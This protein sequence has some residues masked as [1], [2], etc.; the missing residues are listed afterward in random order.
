MAIIGIDLGTTNSLAC[1]WHEGKC[2][3]IPNAFGEVFTPS[4][5]SVNDDGSMSVGKA[6]KER[7][8]SHPDST[9]A[10]FKRFMGTGKQFF[11]Q[12]K[13]FSAPELS[14]FV[15]R[16]LKDDAEVWLNEE[17]SEAIISVPAY[18]N[19]S[20]RAATKLAG[21]LAGVNVERLVNEPSAAALAYRSQ[22]QK[23]DGCFIVFDFGG[24]TLDVSVVECFENI[25]EIISVAGS[26]RLGGDDF[27]HIIANEFCNENK[28]N[29]D[30][31]SPTERSI[32]L[33]GA[34]QCKLNLSSAPIGK[35][36]VDLPGLRGALDITNETLARQSS[37]ILVG[38]RNVMERALKDCGKNVDEIDQVILVGGSCNMPLVQQ[39]VK[40]LMRDYSE[41]IT[42]FVNMPSP[43]AVVAVGVGVYAGIKERGSEIRDMLLTD[44]CP[45]TLGI[46]THN[47]SDHSRLFMSPIIERN[48][49]LPSSR[50]N[51]YYTVYDNQTEIECMIYQG[52]EMHADN[53][54]L[55]GNLKIKVPPAP[56][57][58]ESVDIRFTYDINGL[59]DVEIESVS[60]K[61]KV[62]K[63][64]I[65]KEYGLSDN[66]I[67]QKRKKLAVLKVDP[68][69]VD[70]IRFL[71]ARAE[72]LYVEIAGFQ[73]EVLISRLLR[74]QEIVSGNK[75]IAIQKELVLFAGFLDDMEASL[76]IL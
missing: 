30:E 67:K 3:L 22:N 57:G 58:A 37:E 13:H 32:I 16:K 51:R 63:A 31:L 55:L 41:R 74:F 69:D 20:Q 75:R 5:V 71:V 53:N 61:K 23:K 33:K 7:L 73:R 27:D 49:T 36:H 70:E 40:K 17:V 48:T 4:A 60:T 11:L 43:D 34:A 76:L 46:G 12:K 25:V 29:F 26:N 52:E 18:F 2:V 10:S 68:F 42:P 64:I 59:L 14:S 65:N 6:A 66:D 28:L 54:I 45:F 44:I 8:I 50:V 38:I 15:L 56:A 39:Y 21:S 72:R 19:D 62:S 9:V 47:R 35:M 24:G 1:V